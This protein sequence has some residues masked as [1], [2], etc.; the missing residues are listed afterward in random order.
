M[1]HFNQYRRYFILALM[2]LD[3]LH[4]H[5]DDIFNP[6]KKPINQQRFTLEGFQS[7]HH[8]YCYQGC[9]AGAKGTQFIIK[10]DDGSVGMLSLKEGYKD[11]VLIRYLKDSDSLEVKSSTNDVRYTL[12]FNQYTS[13]PGRF[14]A[15]LH[16]KRSNQTYPI[17]DQQLE[18]P[19]KAIIIPTQNGTVFY[20]IEHEAGK[21]PL[22]YKALE[23]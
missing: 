20:V 13:I 10:S 16:D 11:I 17:S 6:I 14:T 9:I 23:L 18:I 12:K 3:C 21:N 2:V 1:I 5:A 15:T 22:A 8:P 19:Q 4:L 7:A